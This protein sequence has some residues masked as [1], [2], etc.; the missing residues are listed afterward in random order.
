MLEITQGIPDTNS[1]NA[2]TFDKTAGLSAGRG[3]N[4]PF[5]TTYGWVFEDGDGE[6][7][8]GDTDGYSYHLGGGE[9]VAPI[10]LNV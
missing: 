9:S 5:E 6:G 4:I 8:A 3:W 7:S 1:H 10:P 2:S